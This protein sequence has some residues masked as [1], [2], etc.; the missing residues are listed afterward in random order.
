MMRE[1]FSGKSCTAGCDGEK[2][3][4]V[5]A[6]PMPNVKS[7]CKQ[8]IFFGERFRGDGFQIKREVLK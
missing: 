5:P 1:T 2:T 3:L 4:P 6:E 7:W 8:Y